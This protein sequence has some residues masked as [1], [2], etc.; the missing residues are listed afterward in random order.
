MPAALV[1][2]LLKKSNLRV[3][4]ISKAM[5]II[6]NSLKKLSISEEGST[7]LSIGPTIMPPATYPA[8]IDR[9]ALL[10]SRPVSDAATKGITRGKIRLSPPK[11]QV[12]SFAGDSSVQLKDKDIVFGR[13]I[14]I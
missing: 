2:I 11:I 3:R 10:A 5:R 8:T 4:P 12:S 14:R 9:P 7:S 13:K 1:P 6:P